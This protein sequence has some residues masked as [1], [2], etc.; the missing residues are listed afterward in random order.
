MIFYVVGMVFGQS[1]NLNYVKPLYWVHTHW[2]KRATRALIGAVLAVGL[3]AFIFF[4][5]RNNRDQSTVY[6]FKYALPAFLIS[7]IMYG[8]FPVVCKRMGLVAT[9]IPT[10]QKPRSRS[11]ISRSKSTNDIQNLLPTSQI[12]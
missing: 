5:M 4:L 12:A 1:Y 9:H 6:F 8:V 3:Y 7:F 11:T 2:I 10:F